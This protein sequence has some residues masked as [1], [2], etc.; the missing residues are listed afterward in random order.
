MGLNKKV[1]LIQEQGMPVTQAKD[2]ISENISLT[3]DVVVIGSGAGGSVVAYELAKAGKN[4]V[5]LEAGPYVPST[6]FNEHFPEML[7]K[8]YED[9]GA[10]ITKSG[11]LT[12]LQGRCVGGSTVVNGAVCFRTPDVILKKWNTEFGLTDLTK[13][14]LAP[15]FEKVEKNLSVHTNQA[16]EVANPSRLLE[17]GAE[18]LGFSHKPLQRNIKQCAL[19][20]H[21]LSGC[22]TDRKQ[23]MLVTY[24]PWALSHGAKLYADTK[25]QTIEQQ[26]GKVTAVKAVVSDP[27]SGNAVANLTVNAEVVVTAAGAVQT[28][29]LFLQSG[30]G[31]SSGLVGKNFACHPS[32]LMMAEFGEDVYPWRGALLGSYIDEFEHP[33]KGGFILEGGGAGPVEISMAVELGTGEE[34]VKRMEKAK[35][36][37]S[38]V[39]LI[40]DR[41]VGQIRWD[42]DKKVIDYDIAEEDFPAMKNSIKAA[43][44]VFFAAG[45]KH[46]FL[47]TVKKTVVSSLDQLDHEIEQL[48]NQPHTLRMVSYHPQGTMRMGPN[49]ASSVVNEKGES[50]DVK[51]LYVADASLFPT[52]VIVNPQITIY[53]LASYIADQLL[54]NGK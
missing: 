31:N 43:A 13:E 19:T 17:K 32:T 20:G 4:V 54:L 41:N 38:M 35:N 16:H 22:A 53:A 29:L 40:H 30:V 46:V 12:I 8:L 36:I 34:Y 2:L 50:H 7:E 6:E 42:G 1:K 23:S 11:D 51:G 47:P 27:D 26:N 3:A 45:A 48:E 49:S 44:K 25:V 33:D 52:S 10:Q 37:C 18:A 21:C 24:L 28:P 9:R 5:I 15:Y 39:T 14:N